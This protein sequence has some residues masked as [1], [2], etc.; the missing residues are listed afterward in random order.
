[1]QNQEFSDGTGLEEY[2][3]GARFQD[4]QIGRWIRPDPLSYISLN[5]SCYNYAD[6][7]PI[8]YNDRDGLS[9]SEGN[10]AMTSID[11]DPKGNIIRINTD[12]DPGVYMNV[13]N[14]RVLVGFMDP[15]QTY[16]IGGTYH[17]Y[18][19]RDYYDRYPLMSWLGLPTVNPN[20][21]NPDQNNDIAVK[22]NA[23]G[24]AI[25][26]IF[27]NEFTEIFA[28]ESGASLSAKALSA[29]TQAE[30]IAAMGMKE[31]QS[32]AGKYSKELDAFFRTNGGVVAP[33]EALLAYKELTIRM[34]SETG[35]AYQRMTEASKLLQGQR[36]DLINEALNMFYK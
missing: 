16:K 30:K 24:D 6:D 7:N 15:G 19:N 26:A 29:N 22:K 35:G 34:L 5:W 14:S 25:L 12:G 8:R 3:Y 28:S 2:D 32:L 23:L 1:M 20:D 17:Y 36:L 27:L 10:Q 31:V 21:P 13:G 33:K 4:P 18:G 11:L 9:A